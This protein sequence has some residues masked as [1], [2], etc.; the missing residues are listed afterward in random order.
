MDGIRGIIRGSPQLTHLLDHG[1]RVV[2][3]LETTYKVGLDLVLSLELNPLLLTKYIH[4]S[5]Y[6]AGLGQ[7]DESPVVLNQAD[8]HNSTYVK[9]IRRDEMFLKF[10]VRLRQEQFRSKMQNSVE[11]DMIRERIQDFR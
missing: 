10:N 7:I 8:I 5:R 3:N 1:I 4:E 6:L 11:R 2:E 9:I